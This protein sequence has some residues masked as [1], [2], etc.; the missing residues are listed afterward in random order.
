MFTIGA[1]KIVSQC[2]GGGTRWHCTLCD[3]KNSSPG[4]NCPVIQW[5]NSKAPLFCKRCAHLDMSATAHTI[6]T[7]LQ[8]QGIEKKKITGKILD[9]FNLV[10]DRATPGRMSGTIRALSR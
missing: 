9:Q 3:C 4:F 7:F 1:G 5:T 10:P 8:T 6:V 2:Y